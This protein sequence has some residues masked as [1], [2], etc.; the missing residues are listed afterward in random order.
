M[1]FE[2]RKSPQ[3]IKGGQRLTSEEIRE[4]F[5]RYG[6]RDPAGRVLDEP[7][8]EPDHQRDLSLSER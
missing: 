8:K 4:L 3:E 6:S 5:E 7:A 1:C 2:T